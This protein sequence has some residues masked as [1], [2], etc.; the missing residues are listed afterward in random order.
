[1]KIDRNGIEGERGGEEE[2]SGYRSQRER[3][4][5]WKHKV[6]KGGGEEGE[7]VHFFFYKHALF[8]AEPKIA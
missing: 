2:E 3:N 6:G 7:A 1:M 4:Q 8:L 5:T